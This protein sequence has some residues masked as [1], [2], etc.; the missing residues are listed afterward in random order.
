MIQ[1]GLTSALTHLDWSSD[2]KQIVV[3]SS[4]FELKFFSISNIK[5]ISASAAKDIEWYT[6]TC[7]LGFPVQ[8]I[9]V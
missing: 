9:Y 2:S 8:G 4:G 6:W 1:S 5:P 7:T 3:N